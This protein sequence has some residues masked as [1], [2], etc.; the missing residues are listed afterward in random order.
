MVT[1]TSS[2]HTPSI[3]PLELHNSDEETLV[4]RF[5]LSGGYSSE[6]LAHQSE[7]QELLLNLMNC[8]RPALN[9]VLGNR[10]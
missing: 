3:K 5:G 6:I 1:A 2:E 9:D 8:L 10:R 4:I 7:T